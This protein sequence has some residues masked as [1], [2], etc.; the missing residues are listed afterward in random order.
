MAEN[1]SSST[2][3]KRSPTADVQ[4][5]AETPRKGPSD[6]GGREEVNGH[7][8]GDD[9]NGPASFNKD[10]SD[11]A[12]AQ[13][14]GGNTRVAP[15]RSS[16]RVLPKAWGK[17]KD[18]V[19][20]ADLAISTGPQP[21]STRDHNNTKSGDKATE[22]NAPTA[23]GGKGK[24]KDAPSPSNTTTEPERHKQPVHGEATNAG[25]TA[26]RDR[27]RTGGAATAPSPTA[28]SNAFEEFAQAWSNIKPGGAFARPIEESGRKKA[29]ARLDVLSWEL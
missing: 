20:A 14:H 8:K 11:A 27:S 26:L 29:S 15:R 1:V 17:P 12:Q 23:R 9:H 10:A 5:V 2:T 24:M 18:A 4:T 6:S 22:I 3:R 7:A 21:R 25:A 19:T 28:R 13:S 16:G